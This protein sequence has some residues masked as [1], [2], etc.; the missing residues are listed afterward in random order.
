MTST[1]SSLVIVEVSIVEQ[2][3]GT[4][5]VFQET[6]HQGLAVAVFPA[7]DWPLNITQRPVRLSG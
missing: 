3:D 7:P 1:D 2:C 6:I 4:I 5:R